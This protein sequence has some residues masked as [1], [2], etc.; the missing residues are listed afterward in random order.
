[1]HKIKKFTK[2]GPIPRQQSQCFCF[3]I[4]PPGDQ[5]EHETSNANEVATERV[6]G[7]T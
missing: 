1:M 6:P 4:V 5:V 3:P 7:I 2:I